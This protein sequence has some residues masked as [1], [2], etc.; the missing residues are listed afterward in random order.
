[1][2]EKVSANPE[3]ENASGD[4]PDEGP[5]Y[6]EI[7]APVPPMITRGELEEAKDWLLA[8][9]LL[10]HPR[11]IGLSPAA[12]YSLARIAAT[13]PQLAR[14]L[15][16]SKAIEYLIYGPFRRDALVTILEGIETLVRRN[17]KVGAYFND[18]GLLD[19]HIYVVRGAMVEMLYVARLA[20]LEASLGYSVVARSK[21]SVPWALIPNQF[22][23]F[24]REKYEEY[25]GLKM[26]GDRL[27]QITEIDAVVPGD[28]LVE[29]KTR[30]GDQTVLEHEGFKLGSSNFYDY[31]S[32]A[33]QLA[34]AKGDNL[35][36]LEIALVMRGLDEEWTETLTR[37]ASSMETG[38]K[39]LLFPD[40][41]GVPQV[42]VDTMH[43]QETRKKPILPNPQ[44][45][46]PLIE[47]EEG[48]DVNDRAWFAKWIPDEKDRKKSE[49]KS[50]HFIKVGLPRY[51]A[52]IAAG[53]DEA[54]RIHYDDLLLFH[55]FDPDRGAYLEHSLFLLENSGGTNPPEFFDR[56]IEFG[57]E[58]RELTRGDDELVM[59]M[60][61]L[62][63]L[64]GKGPSPFGD[65]VDATGGS[66]DAGRVDE[67]R[68]AG[69]ADRT[70]HHEIEKKGSNSAKKVP[71]V[72]R[73][74][75]D[76]IQIPA[77]AKGR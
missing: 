58:V 46:P 36:G 76:F 72:V 4:H 47:K 5:Q 3:I 24:L 16:E 34:V 71:A 23:S 26:D 65:T 7:K 50:R 31:L 49:E 54:L 11:A 77:A 52:E 28:R 37:L 56:V 45:L 18:F 39:I 44:P 40:K 30:V 51:A 12:T 10:W 62:S 66:E 68:G 19:D 33:M 74:F 13:N 63:A 22:H 69:E 53:I 14:R 61:H 43:Q 25:R 48:L 20:S 32:P 75:H 17:V 60:K 21:R 59:M 8:R 41:T 29:I 67:K 1:M 15:L 64:G 2:V 55:L 70:H 35:R 38:I 57:L 73:R 42:V 6:A 27:R 9:G